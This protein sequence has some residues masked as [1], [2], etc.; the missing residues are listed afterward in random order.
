MAFDGPTALDEARRFRPQVVLLDIGLP[1]MSGYDVARALRRAPEAREA[2]LIA[3]TG[4]GQEEDRKKSR[5]AGFDAHLVRP[6][7]L[8]VLERV[9][10]T[11]RR[12]APGGS[13]T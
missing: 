6:V 8:E 12:A 1:S 2:L 11:P 4:W 9:I 3:Q 5:E 13:A 10:E 7:R